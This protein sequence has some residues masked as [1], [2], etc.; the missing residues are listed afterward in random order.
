MPVS[1]PYFFNHLG[2]GTWDEHF[3]PDEWAAVYHFH[4]P[5]LS[6]YLH[7]LVRLFV[8]WMWLKLV[9]Q[10]HP[11]QA[12]WIL[13]HVGIVF[14]QRED[15]FSFSLGPSGFSSVIFNLNII[16]TQSSW[17]QH[18]YGIMIWFWITGSHSVVNSEKY[19]FQH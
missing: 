17:R 7:C 1:L 19:A 13:F 5:R 15:V 12:V 18:N 14:A 3:L 6:T 4:S 11:I 10:P 16:A 8:M 9:P 2:I